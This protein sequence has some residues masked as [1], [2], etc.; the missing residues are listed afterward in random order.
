MEGKGFRFEGEL[1]AARA[2]LYPLFLAGVYRMVGHNYRAARIAQGILS[3]ITVLGIA[4]WTYILFGGMS[5]CLAALMASLYPAF[6][7]YYFG[8]HALITETLYVFL[9]TAALYTFHVYW[10]RPSWVWGLISGL[11]W[12][13]ANLTR[14]VSLPLLVVLPL[15][16]TFLRYP[17]RQAFR[18][19][20]AVWLMAGLAMGS[21]MLRNYLVF[22]HLVPVSTNG[23]VTLYMA[24]HPEDR[25]GMG[26]KIV[27]KFYLHEEERLKALGISEADRANYFFRKGLEA[28]RDHPAHAL[29]VIFRRILLY[30]DPRTTLFHKEDK[31]QIITWGYLFVLACTVLGFFISL[32]H[33]IHQREIL[34]LVLI[35]GYFVLFHA[36]I[37]A[38]ERY[39][40]PTEPIL[41]VI[42]SFALR[43]LLHSCRQNLNQALEK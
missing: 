33:K 2:P 11:F 10:T 23:L 5:A 26:S 15:I 34:S 41:I 12:G 3:T 17:L 22:H 18:Y 32:K 9:L 1:T 35:F 27:Y 6:Y 37:G 24:F 21:W 43:F 40:F 28:I 13:L 38:S 42:T 8:C 19:T 25:D 14:P 16:L 30:M 31:R 7:A 36:F 4:L 39:R 29:R 20:A